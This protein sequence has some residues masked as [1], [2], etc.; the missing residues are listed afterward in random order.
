MEN[1]EIII[2]IKENSASEDHIFDADRQAADA[3]IRFLN[4]WIPER[5]D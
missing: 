4:S 3:L 5:Q 1:V 2:T